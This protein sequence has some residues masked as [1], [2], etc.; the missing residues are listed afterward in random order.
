MQAISITA[1]FELQNKGV[2]VL[3]GVG[4]SF[5]D[6]VQRINTKLARAT[7]KHL[8]NEHHWIYLPLP[9]GDASVIRSTPLGAVQFCME[10]HDL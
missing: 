10:H 8:G 2:Q 4:K 1:A 6:A 9:E 3:V 5:D 7:G